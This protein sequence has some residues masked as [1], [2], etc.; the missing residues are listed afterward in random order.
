MATTDISA[1]R[2][3][4]TSNLLTSRESSDVLA[5]CYSPFIT[6]LGEHVVRREVGTASSLEAKDWN[7]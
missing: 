5:G 4:L 7:R 1:S 2:R 3:L 6:G